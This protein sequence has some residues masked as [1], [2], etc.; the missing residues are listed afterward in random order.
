[1][2]EDQDDI[3]R[4]LQDYRPADPPERLRERVLSAAD[5]GR[6]SRWSWRVWAIPAAAATAI[7]VAAVG[8]LVP[9]ALILIA[10]EKGF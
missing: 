1:M 7:V 8:R 6:T 9:V 5:G 2:F 4:M 10:P 3:E